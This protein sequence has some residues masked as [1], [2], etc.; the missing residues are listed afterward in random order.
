MKKESQTCFS[1]MAVFP[2][3]ATILCGCIRTRD[4]MMNARGTKVGFKEIAS[5]LC[6]TVTLKNFDTSRMLIFNKFLKLEKSIK[7]VRFQFQWIKPSE[8][9]II[10]NK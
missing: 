1:H 10:I 4:L 3:G 7:E 2:F 9:R 8:T 5:G 6:T